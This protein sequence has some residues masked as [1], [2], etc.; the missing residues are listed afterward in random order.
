MPSVS[1]SI[2]NFMSQFL[3]VEL[4]SAGMVATSGVP[5]VDAAAQESLSTGLPAIKKS[6]LATDG[7][8]AMTVP[9]Y[10]QPPLADLSLSR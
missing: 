3:A 10:K 9:V 7:S 2:T 8:V 6:D 1:L 4:D 5:V